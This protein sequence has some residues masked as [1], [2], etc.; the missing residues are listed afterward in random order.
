MASFSLFQSLAH[1]P[2]AKQVDAKKATKQVETKAP[3]KPAHTKVVK[4]AS[5]KTAGEVQKAVKRKAD[6][7]EIDNDSDEEHEQDE[8]KF[9]STSL[10]CA[11]RRLRLTSIH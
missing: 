1:R 8:R 5:T 6:V 11:R 3:A 9:G 10:C 7:I 2:E 4:V